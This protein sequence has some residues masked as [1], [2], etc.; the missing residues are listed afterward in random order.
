MKQ[1][2]KKLI[3]DDTTL[4]TMPASVHIKAFTLRRTLIFVKHIEMQK[5]PTKIKSIIRCVSYMTIA[6]S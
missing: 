6:L 4:T 1:N 5:Q 2:H 3:S